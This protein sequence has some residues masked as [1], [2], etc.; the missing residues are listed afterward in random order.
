MEVI[1]MA[2]TKVMDDIFYVG[3]LDKDLRVF[4]IIMYSE[5]GTTYNA[6]LVKGS[7]KTVFFQN[8]NKEL[9]IRSLFHV[10]F[11]KLNESL[12]CESDNFLSLALQQLHENIQSNPGFPWTVSYMAKQLHI[13][14]RHLHKI[15]HNQFGTSCMEDV[16][17]NRLD[18]AKKQLKTTTLSIQKIAELCGYSNTE[19]FSRQFKKQTGFSPKKYR[20]LPT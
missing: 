13:C 11:Y 4:D 18:F 17:N 8:K 12:S 19:H 14:P 15:Y 9:T 6:Y 10:L 7:E 16:I 1:I 5:Y 3:V 2:I 20:D